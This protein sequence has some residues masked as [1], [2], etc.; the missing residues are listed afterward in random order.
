[1]QSA[2]FQGVNGVF[3]FGPDNTTDRGLAVATV[4]NNQVVVIDPAPQG[5]GGA[6]F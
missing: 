3:R 6:G 1:M 2:G 5:F 4:R